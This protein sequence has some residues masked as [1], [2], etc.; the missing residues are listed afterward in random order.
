MKKERKKLLQLSLSL[1]ILLSTIGIFLN[2]KKLTPGIDSDK[3][4]FEIDTFWVDVNSSSVPEGNRLP[5]P[6]D[7]SNGRSRFENFLENGCGI[8]CLNYPVNIV[9]ITNEPKKLGRKVYKDYKKAYEKIVDILNSDFRM[10]NG[11]RIFYFTL[12]NITLYPGSSKGGGSK[13]GGSGKYTKYNFNQ[14]TEGCKTLVRLGDKEQ[15]FD[16]DEDGD[17]YVWKEYLE[18]C[19]M[20]KFHDPHA[21]NIYIHDNYT[22][23]GFKNKDGHGNYNWA[24][25]YHGYVFFDYKRIKDGYD[26]DENYAVEV[27]EV[28]HFLGLD[29]V[30]DLSATEKVATNIMTSA[31]STYAIQLPLN[32][33]HIEER[34][35]SDHEFG[36]QKYTC[37]SESQGDRSIGFN[38]DQVYKMLLYANKH[39]GRNKG[40]GV[41]TTC[42]PCDGGWLRHQYKKY[43]I[44]KS[45]GRLGR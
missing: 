23:D 26:G 17:S 21:L 35:R 36:T 15:L 20:T 44:P 39:I 14:L 19:D 7:S 8:Y 22:E 5:N 1:F 43:V 27:H 28:G 34:S 33:N 40:D 18:D 31:R 4:E 37:P 38:A 24:Y 10:S 6:L 29:H 45:G 16:T 30:C 11:N 12:K 42:D 41:S 13:S 2:F 32:K 3:L 25:D 9:E